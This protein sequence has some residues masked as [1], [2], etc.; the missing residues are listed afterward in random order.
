MLPLFI[1]G[2]FQAADRSSSGLLEFEDVTDS[3]NALMLCNH[4]AIPNPGK[5]GKRINPSSLL[6]LNAKKLRTRL[7]GLSP[8]ANYTDVVTAA[9]RRGWCQLLGSK[10]VM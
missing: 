1:S 9:C 2:L 4:A 5:C 8:R 6:I 7:L 3:L 10:G